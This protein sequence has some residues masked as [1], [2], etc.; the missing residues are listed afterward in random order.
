MKVTTYILMDLVWESAQ[1]VT[2][3]MLLP[4][5]VMLVLLHA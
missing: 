2:S 1:M 4:E 3:K 5:L